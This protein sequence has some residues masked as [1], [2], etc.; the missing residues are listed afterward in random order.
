MN[1]HLPEYTLIP[2]S[3]HAQRF[4]VELRFHS[5]AAETAVRFANWTPGSYKIR[6]YARHIVSAKATAAGHPLAMR[7]TD[8]STY[9]ISAP[10]AGEIRVQFEMMGMDDSVRGAWLD[11]W[12]A[13]FEGAAIFPAIVGQ[14]QSPLRVTV[15]PPLTLDNWKCATALKASDPAQVVD[16]F[17]HYA[18]DSWRDLIDHPLLMGRL[19]V[20][21]FT[22]GG[23]QHRF[24]IAGA[25]TLEFDFDR[26]IADT[27]RI[28]ARQIEIMGGTPNA[29]YL[30]QLRIA[31]GGEGGLEH[32]DS[33]LLAASRDALPRADADTNRHYE[34]LLG[35]ISHEYF[36]L[37]NVK[38]IRPLA[39]TASDLN[40]EAPFPDLWAYEG[41]TAY[42]D[43]WFVRNS[44][45]R[46][47][48]QYLQI[49]AESL[50]RLERTPGRLRQNLV[51]ASLDA[52]I[53]LYQPEP[54]L[55]LTT[56]SYY[57][58]GAMVALALDLQLRWHSDGLHSLQSV[59]ASQ[60]ADW[61]KSP[62]ALEPHA[63]ERRCC[64]LCP[65]AA[66]ETF[67]AR[68]VHGTDDPDFVTLFAAF[69][70]T[71][72]RRSIR[73]LNDDGG[74]RSD[75]PLRSQLGVRLSGD[76]PVR[77][78]LTEPESCAEKAGICSGD[79]LLRINDLRINS[80]EDVQ[81]I[82]R[83][84]P[85][86]TLVNVAWVHDGFVRS[87]DIALDHP[88]Q[89]RWVLALTPNAEIDDATRARRDSWL[90]GV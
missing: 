50:T 35:L 72:Q 32:L 79:E 44:G 25:E 47:A 85:P 77:V 20:Q 90:G 87:A 2:E 62:A 14:E 1:Q 12:R 51:E 60:Y 18:A 30:F 27:Q 17:G 84:L 24:A 11:P 41:V 37:W 48:S 89:D 52:W 80:S 59:L 16:G 34:R 55:P 4:R 54:H 45:R 23:C 64:E 46:S 15:R 10:V 21:D 3:P 66:L 28:V 58:K 29:E 88:A 43:D 68:C 70:V 53:R 8:K 81:T 19:R 71:A 61:Q 22:A 40:S 13:H 78:A 36:H 6:D 76:S 65:E 38:R 5:D 86:G 31:P 9:V 83:A 82:L 67:F 49:L 69:G 56:V 7:K 74:F 26:L 63:L 39:V 33:T 73:A 75:A 42:F 57:L